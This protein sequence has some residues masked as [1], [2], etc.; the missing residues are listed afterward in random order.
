M[1][2]YEV[3][4]AYWQEQGGRREKMVRCHWMGCL[5]FCAPAEGRRTCSAVAW[6][7]WSVAW[8]A[9]WGSCVQRQSLP[10]ASPFP[11]GPTAAPPPGQPGDAPADLSYFPAL[12]L[13]PKEMRGHGWTKRSLFLCFW[14]SGEPQFAQNWAF[15]VCAY[16]TTSL[17][18]HVFT[19]DP[20]Y[21]WNVPIRCFRA[22]HNCLLLPRPG[23][24]K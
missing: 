3:N 11:L 23:S 21:R 24:F 2:I 16:H 22:F 19:H 14:H 1:C 5:C 13:S 15:V 18:H 17:S 8:T 7:G 20:I 9:R 10:T 6:G 12:W 4:A